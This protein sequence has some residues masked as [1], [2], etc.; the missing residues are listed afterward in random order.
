MFGCILMTSSILYGIISPFLFFFH[1][2][3]FNY[4]YM[5]LS[6]HGL[7]VFIY[8]IFFCLFTC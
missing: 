8:R 6:H 4:I 7:Y 1:Y 3:Y 2:F 5:S